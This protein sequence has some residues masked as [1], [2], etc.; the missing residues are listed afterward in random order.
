ME[1]EKSPYNTIMNTELKI[2]VRENITIPG[3]SKPNEET[4]IHRNDASLNN[5]YSDIQVVTCIN[6]CFIVIYS[7]FTRYSLLQNSDPPT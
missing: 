7:G 4:T 3:T 6:C 1:N 2:S 5:P